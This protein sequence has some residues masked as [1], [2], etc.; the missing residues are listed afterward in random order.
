ML[1]GEITLESGYESL[2]KHKIPADFKF[3]FIDRMM[4]Q[5]N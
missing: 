1:T 5:D 3:V 4:P 2:R